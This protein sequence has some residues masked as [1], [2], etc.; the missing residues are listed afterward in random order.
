MEQKHPTR[1]ECIKLL[2]DFNTPEHVRRHCYAVTET[3]VRVAE[4]LNKNGFNLDIET[5]RGAG[6]LHDIARVYENH[7][8]KGADIVRNLGYNK[9]ADIIEKHMFYSFC[10]DVSDISEVD[11]VCLGDRLVKEDV[12]VG[13]KERMDYI[14]AKVKDRPNAEA[15]LKEKTKESQYLIHQIEDVI[16][17]TIDKLMKKE[18]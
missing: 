3:A 7:G 11:M 18:R 17:I 13:L 16:G 5:I 4:E 10:K 9:E 14:L 15:I 8:E 1:E 2:E 6:M 12:Y